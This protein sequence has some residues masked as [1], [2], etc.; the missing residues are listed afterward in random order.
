MYADLRMRGDRLVLTDLGDRSKGAIASLPGARWSSR[1]QDFLFNAT[2]ITALQIVQALDGQ[3]H[4]DDGAEDLLATA[5]DI[6]AAAAFKDPDRVLPELPVEPGTKLW[7]HQHAAILFA[8]RLKAC[9]WQI[10]LGAGKTLAALELIRSRRHHRVLVVAPLAVLPAWKQQVREHA[11]E[12]EIKILD[13][14]SAKQKLAKA[15]TFIPVLTGTKR[16]LVVNYETLWRKPFG[17][18]VLRAGF[19]LVIYDEAHKLKSPGSKVSLYARRLGAAVPHTLALTGT[20]LP[21]SP[22]DAYALFRGLG[23]TG[24]FGSSF[25]RFR[26]KYA[27]MGGYGGY[28]VTGYKNTD[29][30]NERYYRITFRAD[31]DVLDLPPVQHVVRSAPLPPGVRRQ[32]ADLKRHFVIDVNEGRVTAGNA[33]VRLLRLQQLASGDLALDGG[34]TQEIH[35]R[36]TALLLDALEEIGN[37]PVVVFC[38]FRRDLER[39]HEV[40]DHLGRGSLEISG[41][42]KELERWQ[43]DSGTF[44][45]LAA[46]IQAGGVGVSMVRA[47]YVV[48]MSLGFS[49]ADYEQALARS[50]RPGQDRAVTYV[51]LVM[52]GTVDEQVHQALRKKKQVIEEILKEAKKA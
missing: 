46:Q 15:A 42:Y 20:P 14:G 13:R 23:E 25:A 37:E 4:L 22:L 17:E 12:I 11:P 44:P 24:L 36:K 21:S 45:I 48:F 19:D 5:M 6:D 33:L 1:T 39:V 10:G 50:H 29:D 51:H 49:L 27:E 30:F 32:Y 43:Q 9:L 52:E 26:A 40:A 28:E 7:R 34:E 2:P 16:I 8:M 38:R 3:V 35:K 31:R 47:R 18:W 41:E